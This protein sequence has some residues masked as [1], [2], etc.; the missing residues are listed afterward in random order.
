LILFSRY[1]RPITIVWYA[2]TDL[3]MGRSLCFSR[4][5]RRC[6]TPLFEVMSSP[7]RHFFKQA[8]ASTV[9]VPIR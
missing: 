5:V 4:V 7:Q 3:V 2:E 1:F 8:A 9:A 6:I